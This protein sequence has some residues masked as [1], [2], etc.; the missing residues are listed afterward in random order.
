MPRGWGAS[1][2]GTRQ[3]TSALL[4]Y[5]KAFGEFQNYTVVSDVEYA[6]YVEFGTKYMPANAA[7]RNAVSETM[8]ELDSILA[9]S[10]ASEADMGRKIAESIRDKWK[11][12][13]W[14]DTGKLQRSIHIEKRDS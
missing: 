8:A 14:V 5:E 3:A 12:D 9:G 4:A 11:R 1:I 6:V 10:F 2:T 13:V 7:L